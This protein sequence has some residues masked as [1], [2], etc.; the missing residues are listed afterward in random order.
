MMMPPG[1]YDGWWRS[2]TKQDTLETVLIEDHSVKT[3]CSG[4]RRSYGMPVAEV[5]R[6]P[7]SNATTHLTDG[8]RSECNGF[9]GDNNISGRHQIDYQWKK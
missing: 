8:L 5:S 9:D 3:F 1:Q 7:N 4:V 6:V 2:R